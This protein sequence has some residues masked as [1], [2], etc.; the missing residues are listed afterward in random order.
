MVYQEKQRN[1]I[2]IY[3]DK[4]REREE[5][6][7]WYFRGNGYI[8]LHNNKIMERIVG[9]AEKVNITPTTNPVFKS[10]SYSNKHSKH[11]PFIIIE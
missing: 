2:F 7:L 5:Y 11:D 8:V 4:E 9:T 3:I 10:H 1:V 6:F